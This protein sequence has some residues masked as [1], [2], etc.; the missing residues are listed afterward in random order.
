MSVDPESVKKVMRGLPVSRRWFVQGTPLDYDFRAGRKGP[1]PLE[2]GAFDFRVQAK[3][4]EL[5][6]FGEYD[7]A[8]GGGANPFLGVRRTDG[9]VCGLDVERDKAPMFLLNSSLD[10]FIETFRLLDGYLA[11][12]RVVPPGIEAQ[13][14][15]IDPKAFGRSDW[16]PFVRYAL[17]EEDE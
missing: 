17:A 4:L 6:I 8:E 9:A 7:Y 12:K 13:L 10:A 14:R 5:L 16:K 1:R 2:P 11:K 3:W 15:K